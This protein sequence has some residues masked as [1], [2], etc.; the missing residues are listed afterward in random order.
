MWNVL[1]HLYDPSATFQEVW[2]ILESGGFLII[3]IPN[4]ES[5]AAKVFG[6]Y[7]AGLD[8]PRHLFLF[9]RNLLINMAEKAG[10]VLVDISY[11]GFMWPTSV[12]YWHNDL[13]KH[14]NSLKSKINPMIYRLSQNFLVRLLSFPFWEFI[15]RIGFGENVTFVF[16]K[17]K[18][19]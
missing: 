11:W 5:V 2:Q 1:E 13:D 6:K 3:R 16:K 12:K 10:F 4:P 9:R 17:S 18:Y 15:N 19:G 7:W 14:H 8:L